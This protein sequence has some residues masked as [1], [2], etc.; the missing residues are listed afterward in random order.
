MYAALDRVWAHL[1]EGA[2]LPGDAVIETAPRGAG[3]PLA[4]DNLEIPR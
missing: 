2:A 1:E 4:A 3:K